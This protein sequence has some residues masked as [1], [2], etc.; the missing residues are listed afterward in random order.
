M[1]NFN[2]NKWDQTPHH[3]P[4]ALVDP[5]ADYGRMRKKFE[6][7]STRMFVMILGPVSCEY[8]GLQGSKKLNREGTMARPVLMCE[9]ILREFDPNK[10]RMK[11]VWMPGCY[12]VCDYCLKRIEAKKFEY[13]GDNGKKS[14]LY[15]GCSL[16]LSAVITRL[17]RD[18]PDHFID[19]NKEYPV[20]GWD[21]LKGGRP[22]GI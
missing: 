4:G 1:A 14:E 2:T 13:G 21:F 12:A 10:P 5:Y 15:V 18:H 17:K 8:H 19:L 22:Q 16:C 6:T 9:H 3:Q 20:E 11:L 7:S